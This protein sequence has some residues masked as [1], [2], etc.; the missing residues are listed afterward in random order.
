MLCYNSED[1]THQKATNEE[2][3]PSF[4]RNVTKESRDEFFEIVQNRKIPRRE[5]KENVKKWAQKQEKSVLEEMHKFDASQRARFAE[6]HK[7]V[8]LV[9]NQLPKAHEEVHKIVTNDSLS[10]E[11][12]FEK[13]RAIDVDPV[14][15]ATLYGI[16]GAF[17]QSKEKSHHGS[18]VYEGLGPL[19]V[20]LERIKEGD[21][22]LPNVAE[23]KKNT[24]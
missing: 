8:N 4:L 14:V 19:T 24:K 9:I 12:M 7:K 11:E 20:L 22:M 23:K 15:V 3:L 10:K 16:V 17:A 21:N 5:L 6:V 13:F 1:C 18:F 2:H